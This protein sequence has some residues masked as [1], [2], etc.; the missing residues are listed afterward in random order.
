[1]VCEGKKFVVF[2]SGTTLTFYEIN[3][4]K[5]WQKRWSHV[6]VTGPSTST[7]WSIMWYFWSRHIDLNST[8]T[9]VFVCVCERERGYSD[10][11]WSSPQ[12]TYGGC[13]F[14]T[15]WALK[16]GD[17]LNLGPG[18]ILLS[19]DS[20]FLSVDF[21]QVIFVETSCACWCRDCMELGR[22]HRCFCRLDSAWYCR[23][24]CMMLV[25]DPIRLGR[26]KS[27]YNTA[28]FNL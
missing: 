18:F 11:G 10:G 6:R 12:G 2:R 24:L 8:C 4:I 1:M 9:F 25:L 26:S 5:K 20:Y 7:G 15:A 16:M 21:W 13:Y 3:Y 28:Q 27:N 17:F 22:Q 19:C 23:S 14:V